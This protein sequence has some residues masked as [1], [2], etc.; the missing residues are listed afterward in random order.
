MIGFYQ[1]LGFSVLGREAYSKISV[2]KGTGQNGSAPL[3]EVRHGGFEAL[4]RADPL[5]SV[6]RQMKT[7]RWTSI[8]P[9]FPLGRGASRILRGTPE[10]PSWYAV[11]AAGKVSVTVMEFAR[12]PENFDDALSAVGRHY[13]LAR[14]RINL[15]NDD[16]PDMIESRSPKEAGPA[17]FRLFRSHGM[18]PER[19]P[20]TCWLD[21][22]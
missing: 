9:G 2:P 1:N 13:G 3:A 18:A 8:N 16:L 15:T 4:R 11:V 19:A 7:G 17:Y 5:R 20:D 21:R 10:A 6:K 22:V 14:L 12:P